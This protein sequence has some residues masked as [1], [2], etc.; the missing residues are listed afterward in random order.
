MT[1]DHAT[2]ALDRVH[3]QRT[4]RAPLTPPHSTPF[5]HIREQYCGPAAHKYLDAFLPILAHAL[6]RA[7]PA[8]AANKVSGRFF[9]PCGWS[10]G[11]LI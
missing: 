10:W 3:P 7:M 9:D 2:Q 8:A 6:D 11:G 4:M 5:T 1:R